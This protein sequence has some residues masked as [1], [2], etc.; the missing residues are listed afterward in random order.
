MT[1]EPMRG[2]LLSSGRPPEWQK[3]TWTEEEA[4]NKITCRAREEG[5]LHMHGQAQ[6]AELGPFSHFTT[7]STLV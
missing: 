2:G 5:G 6:R 7:I 3:A 1:P 4:E